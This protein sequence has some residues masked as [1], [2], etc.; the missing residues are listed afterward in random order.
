MG[1]IVRRVPL[2]W[3]HPTDDLGKPIP[4]LDGINFE[5]DMDSAR[6]YG[7]DLPNPEWYTPQWTEEEADGWVL[8]ENVSEGTPCTP[9]FATEDEL[10]AW[11]LEHGDGFSHTGLPSEASVDALLRYGSQ[12][13]FM[14]SSGGAGEKPQVRS[15]T[16][17]GDCNHW[18]PRAKKRC[19]LAQGHKPPHRHMTK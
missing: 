8:Y 3:E 18:M 9:V 10:R 11:L 14:M 1:R 15:W 4:L 16:T 5:L 12:P 19:N 2:N 6:R 13:S 17:M 7:D